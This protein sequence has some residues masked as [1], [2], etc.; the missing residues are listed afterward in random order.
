M[1]ARINRKQADGLAEIVSKMLGL[2][3]AEDNAY[4][5]TALC[6][7]CQ[8]RGVDRETSH[9]KGCFVYIQGAYDGFAVRMRHADTG[10]S[11]I[12]NGYVTLRE[13]FTFLQGMRAAL[14]EIEV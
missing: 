4:E 1:A 8:R 3:Y 9:A 13:C 14:L 5:G 2:P 10:E 12:G 7:S 6:R 11:N